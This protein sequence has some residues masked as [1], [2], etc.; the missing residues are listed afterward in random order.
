MDILEDLVKKHKF[1]SNRNRKN[2]SNGA[3]VKYGNRSCLVKGILSNTLRKGPILELC[4]EMLGSQ[5][6]CVCLNKNVQC[7]RH[8][9]KNNVGE[10]YVCYFG[11]FSGGALI[12]ENG[13]RF[14]GKGKWHGSFDG[15]TIEHWNEPHEGVK[16]SVVA[17]AAK[18]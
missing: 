13:K 8:V 16:Y 1:T 11:D 17:F 7:A 15:A 2:I 10:S 14:E 18:V 3:Q 5:I 6:T 9:D 12:L 4:Q